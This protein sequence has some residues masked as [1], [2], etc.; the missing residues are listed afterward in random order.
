MLW[1]RG[2]SVFEVRVNQTFSSTNIQIVIEKIEI[3]DLAVLQNLPNERKTG[4]LIQNLIN[5]KKHKSVIEIHDFFILFIS[6]IP[7]DEAPFFCTFTL[8]VPA[9]NLDFYVSALRNVINIKSFYF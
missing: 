9:F 5:P 4:L 6:F 8:Y 2:H 7:F 1:T 3:K